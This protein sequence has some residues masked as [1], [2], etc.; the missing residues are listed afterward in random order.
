MDRPHEGEPP[1]HEGEERWFRSEF[2]E[3][4][5]HKSKVT[6]GIFKLGFIGVAGKSVEGFAGLES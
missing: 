3:E 1:L 5:K 6:E 4:N 2:R